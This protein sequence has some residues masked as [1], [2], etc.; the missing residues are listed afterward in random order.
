[1]NTG[2]FEFRLIDV[3]HRPAGDPNTRVEVKRSSDSRTID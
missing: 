2:F 1:M 3:R